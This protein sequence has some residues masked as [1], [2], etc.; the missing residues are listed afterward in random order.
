MLAAS[1]DLLSAI[2]ELDAV[3]DRLDAVRLPWLRCCLLL[4]LSDLRR[5]AGQVSAARADAA[6]ANATLVGLDVELPAALRETLE[7]WC[8]TGPEAD[9]PHGG[10]RS[11]PDPGTSAR[12]ELRR[13][14]TWWVASHG[15]TS[16]RLRGTKGLGY[17]AEL[18]RS[19]GAE[20]HS[21]DLVDAVE[22]I[23]PERS[24]ER[25]HLG[26]A[27][28]ALDARAR[29]AYRHRVEVLRAEA[30]EALALGNLERA[31]AAQAEIDQFVGQLAAAFGLGGSDRR[32]ASAA[33]RARVN[34]T[35]ALRAAISSL[36]D[37]L[38]GAGDV[39]DQRV[40]TGTYCAYEPHEDDRV[41]W[42]A[43]R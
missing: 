12:A 30:D 16:V 34:V 8:G 42:T 33:E 35:R 4:E 17:L 6:A 26:D 24:V 27:G 43:S 21:L 23:D 14:G 15:G 5:R 40:R 38:P 13:D 32:A 1:G 11:E 10:R 20:R 19:P 3:V 31:E 25:R 28:E 2:S 36:S 41:R 22:G 18:L 29:A 39:L 37:A 9:R 7:R